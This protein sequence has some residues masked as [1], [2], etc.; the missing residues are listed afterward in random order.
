MSCFAC[1]AT[2]AVPLPQFHLLSPTSLTTVWAFTVV[3]TLSASDT[4]VKAGPCLSVHT[5]TCCALTLNG[6]K[7]ASQIGNYLLPAA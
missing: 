2:S 6:K 1:A 4:K 7:L 3:L 5:C